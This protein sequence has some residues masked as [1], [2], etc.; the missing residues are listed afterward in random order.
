M[1]GD[2]AVGIESDQLV[3]DYLSRVGDLA[4][5]RQ[6]PS[7]ARRELVTGLRGEIDRERARGSA[8]SP[9]AVRRILGRLGTPDEVVTAAGGGAPVEPGGADVPSAPSAGPGGRSSG[10]GGRSWGMSKPSW[11]TSRPPSGAAGASAENGSGEDSAGSSGFAGVRM[12]LPRPRKAAPA[13]DA[14]PVPP[15]PPAGGRPPHLA[16]LDELGSGEQEA[17]WWHTGPQPFGPGERIAGFTG[18]VEIP[19]ILAPPRPVEPPADA[20]DG[21]DDAEG[22]GAEGPVDLPVEKEAPA[23]R[24]GGALRVLG[25]LALL[26]RRAP[27]PDTVE[28]PAAVPR[29]GG[30][31]LILAAGL[32]VTGAVL[33]SWIALGLG[34]LLAWG[35]G[36]LSETERR[37]AVLGMPGAAVAVTL[38]WLWGREDGRWGEPIPPDGG[39]S[40][41]ISGAAPWTIKGAAVASAL[42]LLWRSRRA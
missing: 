18:G 1:A 4:Q 26:R 23:R 6:L 9:A 40:D 13:S 5:Q 30:L 28:A 22:D 38:V 24:G 8:D 31:V 25:V 41:A 32:L 7:G 10:P 20:A 19:E 39:L 17:D 29:A 37:T 33:A 11:G 34:W 35:F 21:D 3:Y 2:A 27:A 36:R 42:F 12:R 15:S 16:G 14:P